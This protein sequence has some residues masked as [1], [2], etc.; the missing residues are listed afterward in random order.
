M[1]H[2]AGNFFI[3]FV[4]GF[5]YFCTTFRSKKMKISRKSNAVVQHS[6]GVQS[7]NHKSERVWGLELW[8]IQ[9]EFFISPNSK[10][11]VSYDGF[12]DSEFNSDSENEWSSD[13]VLRVSSPNCDRIMWR[14]LEALP[15]CIQKTSKASTND[16][17]QWNNKKTTGTLEP[18]ES[19]F[20][21][22]HRDLASF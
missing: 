16:A 6:R 18:S 4:F 1:I 13:I 15:N 11:F 19:P 21:Q 14:M 8:F 5:W 9:P 22:V 10:Y 17:K 2:T 20:G 7:F 12:P 3:N